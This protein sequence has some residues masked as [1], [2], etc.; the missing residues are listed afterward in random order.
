MFLVEVGGASE[1]RGA[2]GCRARRPLFEALLGG[3]EGSGDLF[4]GGFMH[5]ADHP[6]AVGGGDGI[7]RRA[8]GSGAAHQHGACGP[9]GVGKCFAGI[10]Q[11]QNRSGFVDAVALG[12]LAVGLKQLAGLADQRA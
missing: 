7:A 3:V 6:R 1:Y 2:F 4:R 8:L 12:I 11:R 10:E 5:L 9:G